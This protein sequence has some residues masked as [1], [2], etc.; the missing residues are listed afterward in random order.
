MSP[1]EGGP[2]ACS[3]FVSP[4]P[5]VRHRYRSKTLGTYNVLHNEVYRPGIVRHEG[6][7]DA[8]NAVAFASRDSSRH[9]EESQKQNTSASHGSS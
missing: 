3:R 1:V 4:G 2:A 6:V 5:V 8:D 9:C 7:R